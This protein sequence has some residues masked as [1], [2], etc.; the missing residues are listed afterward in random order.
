[1]VKLALC[2]RR[3]NWR[4]LSV[5][6]HYPQDQNI[7]IGLRSGNCIDPQ[8]LFSFTAGD[9]LLSIYKSS[10]GFW[11]RSALWD[12]CRAGSLNL[13]PDKNHFWLA[14][15]RQGKFKEGIKNIFKSIDGSRSVGMNSLGLGWRLLSAVKAE[16]L[17]PAGNSEGKYASKHGQI[18]IVIHR[19]TV[20]LSERE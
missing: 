3:D 14:D 15:R 8:K 9:S 10:L 7:K 11:Q 4:I 18:Q 20:K 13:I 12:C 5:G 19:I 2:Y 1:M 17:G 6:R 16:N